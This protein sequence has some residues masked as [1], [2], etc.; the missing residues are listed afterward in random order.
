MNGGV[1]IPLFIAIFFLFG[2]WATAQET[3]K[4]VDR[5]THPDRNR[6]SDLQGKSFTGGNAFQKSSSASTQTFNYTERYSPQGFVTKSFSNATPY[7]TGKF[8]THGANTAGQYE[9][10]GISKKV[11]SKPVDTKVASASGKS[12]TASSVYQAREYRGRGMSQ[13][14][15]DQRK[16]DSKPLTLDEV[17]EILDK[18]K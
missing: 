1:R 9:I 7:S 8:S 4:L 12:Y 13:D 5:I 10:P 3:Q 6:A 11:D 17:R 14:L 16:R 2:S 18:N 15:F